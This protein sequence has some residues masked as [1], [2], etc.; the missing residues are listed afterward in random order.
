MRFVLSFKMDQVT[1][2]I[3][4]VNTQI[5]EIHLLL[6]KP[7]R[8]WTEEEKEAYGSKEQLMD[9]E[10]HLM[11]ERKQLRDKEKQLRDKE[12]ELLKQ[13]TILLQKEQ[14]QVTSGAAM[15]IDILPF[16]SATYHARKNLFFPFFDPTIEDH[17]KHFGED[18]LLARDHVID[19]VN[20][21]ISM[22]AV[23]KYQPI[24]CSTSRGM[25]KTAFMEAIG[26][27][28]V[29]SQLKNQLIMDA[30]AY[31][32]ILSFDFSG[33]NLLI[34]PSCFLTWIIVISYLLA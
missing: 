2:E 3:N 12:I 18:A 6:K 32:R 13:K 27:Q 33:N 8:N 30:L 14:N 20:K 29:K 7:F 23:E 9:K 25:G 31:G 34:W 26:M 22:R 1:A 16:D 10:K 21:I 17:L 28:L 15:D 4:K 24:I 11:A 19:T 5:D